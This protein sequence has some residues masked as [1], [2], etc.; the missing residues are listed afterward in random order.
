MSTKIEHDVWSN[1]S[2]KA[3]VIS[4]IKWEIDKIVLG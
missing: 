4:S 1:Q 2:M 3:D